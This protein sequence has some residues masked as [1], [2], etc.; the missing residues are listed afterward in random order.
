MNE[1]IWNETSSSTASLMPSG[2]QCASCLQ[3]QVQKGIKWSETLLRIPQKWQSSHF[4][5]ISFDSLLDF[6]FCYAMLFPKTG[7]T[8]KKQE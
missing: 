6:F 8:P 2:F 7:K 1:K 4:L 3:V 5:G